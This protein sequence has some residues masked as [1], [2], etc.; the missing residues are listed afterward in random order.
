MSK[1]PDIG[2]FGGAGLSHEEHHAQMTQRLQDRMHRT[3]IDFFLIVY[4]LEVDHQEFFD[5]S[6]DRCGDYWKPINLINKSYSREESDLCPFLHLR[7][8]GG[9]PSF[10]LDTSVFHAMEKCHYKGMDHNR[11]EVAEGK[12][13]LTD[14]GRMKVEQ[15]IIPNVDTEIVQ[16]RKRGALVFAKAIRQL[17]A[18]SGMK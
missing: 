18:E 7:F 5:M 6:S 12:L 1:R 11:L 2:P 17:R 4:F 16:K 13:K 10:E 14:Y 3:G 15:E 9:G 8:L